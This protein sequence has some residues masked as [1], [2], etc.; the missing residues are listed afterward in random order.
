MTVHDISVVTILATDKLLRV[1]NNAGINN[2]I[3]IILLHFIYVSL[4]FLLK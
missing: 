2:S 3:N 4:F 1:I